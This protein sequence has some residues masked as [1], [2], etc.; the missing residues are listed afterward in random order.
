MLEPN[1]ATLSPGNAEGSS[2]DHEM[3]T[4]AQV[5]DAFIERSWRSNAQRQRDKGVDFVIGRRDGVRLWDLEGR[6][7]VIDC[8]TAGGVHSLGHRH[9]EVLESLRRA[10]DEGRDTGL[11]AIPNAEYLKLQDSLAAHAPSPSLDRSVVTL[12]STLSVDVASMFAFRF[13]GRRVVAAY[14]H[15]YHGHTGFA[16]MVTGSHEEGVIA[17]YN[18]PT[19]HS[20]FFDRYGDLT[21]LKAVL[22]PDVAALILEPMNYETFEP[23]EASY[24]RGAEKLCREQGIIFIIDET[25]TGLGRS[26]RLWA[27]EYSGVTPDMMVTG[28]GLS[29]GLYPASAVLMRRDI[30]DRCMNEHRF[31]YI[32]SLGGNEISCLV[33]AKVLEVS[34]RPETLSHAAHV[35]EILRERLDEVCARH[36]TI[37]TR[38][39]GRG[40]VANV[41]LLP[42]VS[43]R[44]LYKAVFDAGVLCHSVSEIDPPA[45]KFFPPIVITEDDAG[46]IAAALDKAVT[47]LA[48]AAV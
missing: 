13:T 28:K 15:G 1:T 2:P 38:A 9:P 23:A 25:R 39:W 44:A 20:R 32:S 17:H 21:E 35:G 31:A 11:W 24:L 48:S 26:G 22:T 19:E 42:T 8:G 47:A 6:R 16:A 46:E 33:A 7:S 18:L 37:L 3:T 41:G 40:C 4:S 43:G 45:I 10:L 34:A 14:R 12:C 29:G 27:C 5:L 30:Y 36:P